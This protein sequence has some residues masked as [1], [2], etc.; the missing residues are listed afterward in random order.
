[1]KL[2]GA[3]MASVAFCTPLTSRPAMGWLAMNSTPS[4]SM[5][6]MGSTTPHFTPDTSVKI[7][8]GRNRCLYCSTHFTKA[9]G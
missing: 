1:M 5:A 9:A 4:G 8:P 7:S 3:K 6:W 2:A